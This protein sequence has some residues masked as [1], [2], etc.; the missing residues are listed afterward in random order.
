MKNL[1]KIPAR[2][3]LFPMALLIFMHE[4]EYLFYFLIFLV[5]YAA[6]IWYNLRKGEYDIEE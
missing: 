4:G 1:L 2:I 6:G 5:C 3:Y